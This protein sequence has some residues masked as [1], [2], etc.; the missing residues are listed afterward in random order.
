M[1][2]NDISTG[3]DNFKNYQEKV[4]KFSNKETA[5]FDDFHKQILHH[6]KT[7]KDTALNNLSESKESLSNLKAEAEK[8]KDS[9]FYHDETVIVDRQ[10]IISQTEESVHK[11]NRNILDYEYSQAG[12]R[13]DSLDYLNKALIQTK[14]NFFNQ[15]RDHYA[16]QILDNDFLYKFFQFKVEDF[17]RTLEKYHL[18]IVESFKLLNNQINDVDMQISL[19]I[20]QKKS[21]LNTVNH[22]YRQEMTNYLD[23]QLTF[24]VEDDTSSVTIQA[25]ISD[26]ITQLSRF[27]KHLN[28]QEQ[29]VKNILHN[30][31]L[32]LYNKTLDRL[33]KRKGNDLVDDTLFF[34]HP[35]ESIFKL[36][37]EIAAAKEND[38]VTLKDLITKYNR[39]IQY[40]KERHA[41]EKK[42]KLLTKNILKQKREVY[43]VYQKDSRNLVFQLEKYYNLYLE[44]LKIDPFLAQII[45]D[46]STKVIKDELNFLSILQVNK[47][48]KINVTFD[49]KTRKLK[50]QIN[51][52]EAKLAYES[53]KL[54]LEQDIELLSTIKDLQMYFTEHQ[55]DT[56]QIM[57]SL[58]TEKYQIERLEKAINHHMDYQVKETNL[59]RKFL[60]MIT[61]I[62]EANIREEESH[63]IRIVGAAS[64]IK[65]ALK[66]YDILALHFNTMYE[67]EKRFL[68]MQSTRVSEESKINN[69]FILTTFSN[70]MRFAGEQINLA[71]DEYKLRVEAIMTAINEEKNYYY[72]IIDNHLQKYKKREKIVTDEYQAKLY[73]DTLLLTNATEKSLKKAL[74]KQIETNKNIHD[75]HIQIIETEL[76][77]DKFISDAKK[78]LVDLEEH[79]EIALDD[80]K[81]IRND[82]INEMTELYY[83]AEKKFKALKPYLKEKVN[84]LDPTFYNG[85]ERMKKRHNLKLKTAEAQLEAATKDL[86]N[87]YLKVFFAEKH[88]INKDLYL[89]QIEQLEEERQL[90]QEEYS[91][92]LKKDDLVYHSQIATLESELKTYL[93]KI[94]SNKEMVENRHLKS[95]TQK[96]YELDSLLKHYNTKTEE[97]SVIYRTDVSALTDEYNQSIVQNEKY[98]KNLTNAFDSILNSYY[99]YLKTASNNGIIKKIVK[100]T[101]KKMKHLQS[102]ENKQLVKLSKDS[103]YLTE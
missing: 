58:I 68:I 51:Q 71:N 23:N 75:D 3:I 45:G 14:F 46:N 28:D 37:Q 69:E 102:L 30:E 19:L 79:F 50:Q 97:I 60:S 55:Y 22:F 33:L 35:D 63:N 54:M 18:E 21:Q 81:A 66:E 11:E 41:C 9:V 10:S 44:L 88:E 36:K 87:Y 83:D 89:S 39:A 4:E 94:A 65:L 15:F 6:A 98:F 48:H 61:Q 85:L 103:N 57:N 64:Q 99:P 95:I 49:I 77:K 25:L 8:L 24:S 92:K 91:N 59:N 80:A 100:Q 82:T 1:A 2:D 27:K 86:M 52:V 74:E 31:Y 101:E 13:I 47:E 32:S 56:A 78:R 16:N 38:F 90:I 70:Q 40:K 93:E 84:A 73:N 5:F 29:K 26:K 62:L 96:Q 20:Q 76:K 67:N 7:H 17:D 34:S 72:D 42:A 53:E 12:E 43:L